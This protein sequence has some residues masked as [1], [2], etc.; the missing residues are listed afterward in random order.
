MTSRRTLG[1]TLDLAALAALTRRDVT[2]ERHQHRPQD[3]QTMRIAIHELR[4]RGFGDYDI[5]AATGLS[6][7]YVRRVLGEPRP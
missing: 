4:A 6:V 3:A 7:E 5:S 2:A 1:G